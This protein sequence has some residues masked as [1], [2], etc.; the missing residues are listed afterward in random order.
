[1]GGESEDLPEYTKERLSGIKA[2]AGLGSQFT[3]LF[4]SLLPL[5]PARKP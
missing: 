5:K 2:A 1:M 3:G 4:F